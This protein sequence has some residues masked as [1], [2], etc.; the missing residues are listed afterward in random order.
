MTILE[1]DA[2]LHFLLRI[3]TERSDAQLKALCAQAG[4][5]VSALSDYYEDTVPA[6]AERCLLVNYSGLGEEQ[7]EQA[8]EKLSV[9]Q[10]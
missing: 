1:Q 2:G 10:S 7:L 6:W 3:D 9:T 4:I 5:R 8:L